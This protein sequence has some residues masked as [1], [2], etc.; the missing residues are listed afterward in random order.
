MFGRIRERSR[1]VRAG[2][3]HG[4]QDS[5]DRD[6]RDRRETDRAII[7]V[8]TGMGRPGVTCNASAGAEGPPAFRFTIDLK[9][10]VDDDD[11]LRIRPA[12]KGNGAPRLD[13]SPHRHQ[14]VV[15]GIEPREHL[16]AS[17]HHIPRVGSALVA[18]FGHALRG[19]GAQQAYA[20]GRRDLDQAAP[21]LVRRC[22]RRGEGV[23]GAARRRHEPIEDG[24]RAEQDLAH[25]LA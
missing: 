23:D 9:R 17:A 3:A 25:G 4:G 16:D 11:A 7:G 5:G 12:V 8:A 20:E 18:L 1:G 2:R 21:L 6:R 10:A 22:P 19:S 13:P 24:R 15:A 14:I